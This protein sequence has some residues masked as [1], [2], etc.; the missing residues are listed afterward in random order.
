MEGIVPGASM[1]T[2]VTEQVLWKEQ[3]KDMQLFSSNKAFC[4][5]PMRAMP[6][7]SAAS[8][9]LRRGGGGGGGGKQAS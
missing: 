2:G 1:N 3:K 5:G 6:A 8:T 9:V 4:N 7:A